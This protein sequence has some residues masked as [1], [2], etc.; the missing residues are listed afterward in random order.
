MLAEGG[1]TTVTP[2]DLALSLVRDLI[3]LLVHLGQHPEDVLGESFAED[4]ILP[5]QGR[6]PIFLIVVEGLLRL[7]L[8]EVYRL[9]LQLGLGAKRHFLNDVIRFRFDFDRLSTRELIE[10]HCGLGR[11]S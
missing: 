11:V 5:L 6:Q 10:E 4:A 2:S 9:S 1:Q 3:D 7:L 8:P